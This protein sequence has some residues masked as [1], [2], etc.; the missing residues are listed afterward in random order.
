MVSKGPHDTKSCDIS[1]K[2]SSM[3]HFAARFVC[4]G[5][6]LAPMFMGV[7][8]TQFRVECTRVMVRVDVV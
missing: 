5:V 6:R 2:V 3:G 7:V 1:M 8:C 4:L